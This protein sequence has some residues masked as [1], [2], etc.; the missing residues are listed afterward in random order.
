MADEKNDEKKIETELP[1]EFKP[2]EPLTLEERE[3]VSTAARMGMPGTEI[4]I[5]IA[6]SRLAGKKVMDY[7]GEVWMD[8]KMGVMQ[9]QTREMGRTGIITQ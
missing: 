2:R 1:A 6:L 8:I 3:F 9:E 7:Q 4:R 5:V